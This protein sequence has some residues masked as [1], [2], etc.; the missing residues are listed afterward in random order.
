[1]LIVGTIG[2]GSETFGT[3]PTGFTLAWDSGSVGGADTFRVVIYVWN[4]ATN[5]GSVVCTKSGT[6]HG[7]FVRAA[8]RGGTGFDLS[9]DANAVTASGNTHALPAQ[10]TSGADNL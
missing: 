2:T 10:T 3:T 4:G 6:R 7:H 8:W 9:T 1:Q 5:T